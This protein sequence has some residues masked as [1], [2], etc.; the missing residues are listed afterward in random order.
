MC[1]MIWGV[2]LWQTI[3]TKTKVSAKE[4]YRPKIIEKIKR[5]EKAFSLCLSLALLRKDIISLLTK[6]SINFCNS[7]EIYYAVFAHVCLFIHY[8]FWMQVKLLV[9]HTGGAE[10]K[11]NTLS[12][13]LKHNLALFKSSTTKRPD[14][15]DNKIKLLNKVP[16]IH[17]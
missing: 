13:L 9:S 7:Q 4:I 14:T 5:K 11:W 2:A 10:P 12:F 6:K 15:W 1:R 3:Y 17:W 8:M 16:T